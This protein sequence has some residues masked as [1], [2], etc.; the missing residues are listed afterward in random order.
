MP[1]VR[2]VCSWVGLAPEREDIEEPC[3]K[4][5]SFYIEARDGH[6]VYSCVEH[7]AHVKA[8]AESGAA[9]HRVPDH[10]PPDD[11]ESFVHVE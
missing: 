10:S 6:R 7:L 2:P 1:I 9:V 11:R 4:P 8:T 3:G 5:A